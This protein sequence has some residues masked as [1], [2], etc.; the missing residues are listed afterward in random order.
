MRFNIEFLLNK[1]MNED[2]VK[3]YGK[4]VKIFWQMFEQPNFDHEV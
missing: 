4:V 2:R 3:F 1:D